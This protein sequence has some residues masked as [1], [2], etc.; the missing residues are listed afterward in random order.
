MTSEPAK[1]H[2][3]AFDLSEFSS[4]IEPYRQE[5]LLYC[6][7]LLGS[8]HDAEDL[9]QETMLRAWQYSA[10][11]KGQSSLRTWLYKI[12]TNICLDALKKRQPR[13]LP[14][15]LT[16]EADPQFPIAP[17]WAESTWL[18]P[19]PNNW[20]AEAAEDPAARY[21]RQE[22][23]SLAFLTVLQLLPPR[24]RAILLLSDVLDW[25]ASEIANLL[26]ISVSAVKSALHRARVTLAKQY[27]VDEQKRAERLRLDAATQA[28]L[29]R[30][31][32][33]WE[34]RD[35]A[36]LVA[37]MKEDAT[38]TMPPS[39]SW[40]QGR[41]AIRTQIST[42]GLALSLQN[43]WFFLPTGA[44]GGPAFVVYRATGASGPAR[45]FGIQVLT[46]DFSASSMLI[47]DVTTFL[48]PSLFPFFGFPPELPE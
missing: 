28:L 48:D 9:V 1:A 41:E 16:P 44:N 12:A 46:L 24:Q 37:L 8:L 6:Y 35:V 26:S 36:G 33:A 19:F 38:F 2:T 32:R 40:Y 14:V 5:L 34:E 45:A 39:P 18:E 3:E 25:H 20:L 17:P 4:L 29:E 21:S 31:L 30:Y 7:R 42:H 43:R 15:G 10:T 27:H 22:S 23:V 11:F 47:A 13:K